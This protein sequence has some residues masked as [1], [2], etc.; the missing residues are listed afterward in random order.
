MVG[1]VRGR[2]TGAQM[3]RKGTK[4]DEA[5]RRRTNEAKEAEDSKGPEEETSAARSRTDHLSPVTNVF[6]V[7]LCRCLKDTEEAKGDQGDQGGRMG[8]KRD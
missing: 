7:P 3:G 2:G 6:S 8:T 5:G 1:E 4:E